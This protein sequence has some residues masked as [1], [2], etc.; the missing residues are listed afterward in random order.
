[1]TKLLLILS[2]VALIANGLASARSD[3]P[4]LIDSA[5]APVTTTASH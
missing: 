4:L 2:L 3:P 5:P 1:M